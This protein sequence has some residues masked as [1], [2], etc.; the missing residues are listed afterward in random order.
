MIRSYDTLDKVE[1]EKLELGMMRN[2]L[3]H[4]RD[5]TTFYRN[6]FAALRFQPEHIQSLDEIAVLPLLD[7]ATILR[8]PDD[9]RSSAFDEHAMR[10]VQTGGST[11]EPFRILAG[12]DNPRIQNIFNWA[13][14]QRLG[15]DPGQA[16]VAMTGM[17]HPGTPKRTCINA[18]P[19]DRQ[20]WVHRPAMDDSPPW[21]EII[22]QIRDFKPVLLRGFPSI[23][24]ELAQAMLDLGELPFDNLRGVSC[25]SED[26]LSAQ[27]MVIE[28]AF[29]VRCF[30]FYGQSEGC[31]LAMECELSETYHLYPGYAFVEIVDDAGNSTHTPGKVGEVVGSSLLNYAMPLI[32]YRTGDLAS[33]DSGEC[34]CGRQHKRLASLAGRK[35]SR[36]AFP[37]GSTVYFGSDIYDALW[38]SP[39]PFRHIQ[40][41][42]SSSDV[43]LIRVV[44]FAD[45][46]RTCLE[47]F[48]VASMK[49]SLGDAL[50]Y[51]VEFVSK[52][53]RTPRGKYLLFQQK[54]LRQRDELQNETEF[55]H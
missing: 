13:Q 11:G 9:F 19:N 6:T 51:R 10:V 43:L 15:I 2:L 4:A 30:D 46:D 41:E 14:W 53:E 32:R 48:I 26:L 35:R 31:V 18:R 49:Q 24:S 40:F 44:P 20:L 8:H 50:T 39:E 5:T 52:V 34:P 12:R 45:T 3:C 23:V 55:A 47:E 16:V 29:G 42:Q 37:D 1:I 22:T 7:K 38:Y 17:A 25:S 36:L 54:Y 21:R 28:R 33:W 27:R